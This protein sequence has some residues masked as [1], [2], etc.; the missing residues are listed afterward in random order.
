MSTTTDYARIY[1]KWHSYAPEHIAEMKEHFGRYAGDVLPADRGA[2]IL[3]IGCAMGFALIWLRDLGCSAAEGID[4]DEG[5]IRQCREQN[6]PAT[7]VVDVAAWLEARPGQ[8]DLVLAFDL[9]EHLP[10]E[11]Q[12]ALCRAIHSALKPG[13]RLVCTV[14]NANSALASRW[15]Y[16][17]WTHCTSFTEHSLDFLLY[18]AGFREIEIGGLELMA[19]PRSIQGYLRLILKKAFRGIRRL[20]MATELGRREARDIP[21]ALN[22]RGVAVKSR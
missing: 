22:L 15:R 8:F 2:R 12:L 4:V 18:N 10:A 7:H 20:E 1:S 19:P 17:C 3:D 6:L 16:V 5:M 14:P 9:V 11:K 13:G 21:L